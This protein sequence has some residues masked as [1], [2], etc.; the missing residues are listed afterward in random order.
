ME[1]VQSPEVGARGAVASALRYR[2]DVVNGTPNLDR[3]G[4]LDLRIDPET[5]LLSTY[6]ALFIEFLAD[7]AEA[8]RRSHR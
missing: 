8:R 7:Q 5:S 1:I 6:D 3:R 2:P 4:R